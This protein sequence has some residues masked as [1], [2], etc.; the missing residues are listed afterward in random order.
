MFGTHC[1]PH[2]RAL[3]TLHIYAVNSTDNKYLGRKTALELKHPLI[4]NRLLL[5]SLCNKENIQA[6]HSFITF[7]QCAKNN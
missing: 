3:Y 4:R 2:E 6:I 1:V 7:Q 5:L